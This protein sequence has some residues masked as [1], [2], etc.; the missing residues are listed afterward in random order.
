MALLSLKVISNNDAG[1]TICGDCANPKERNVKAFSDGCTR[2]T[3]RKTVTCQRESFVVIV[4]LIG[5]SEEKCCPRLRKAGD[6]VLG[7]VSLQA[8]TTVL[9]MTVLVVY[10]QSIAHRQNTWAS[11]PQNNP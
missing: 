3:I 5:G 6:C 1:G 8:V 2:A 4:R 11:S 10:C 9:A 7:F